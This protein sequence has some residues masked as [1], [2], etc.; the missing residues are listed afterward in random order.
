MRTAA[1]TTVLPNWVNRTGGHG[2][3]LFNQKVAPIVKVVITEQGGAKET[4]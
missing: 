3:K 2:S 1:L 4:K